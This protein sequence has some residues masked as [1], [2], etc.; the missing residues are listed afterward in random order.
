MNPIVS[1]I[2]PVYNAEKELPHAL[3]S[4]NE[5]TYRPIEVCAINDCSTD[6]SARILADFAQKS[7]DICVKISTHTTNR[8][9]AA[10]RNTGLSLA[11]GKYIYYVDADDALEPNALERLVEKAEDN[12]LDIIGHDW[13]LEFEKNGRYM[14]QRDFSTPHEAVENLMY[15]VM[16]W[17]LWLFMTKRSLYTENNILF[18]EGMN[19]GEDMMVTIKLFLSADKVGLLHQGLYHYRQCNEQSLTKVYSKKHIEQVTANVNEVEH[20]IKVHE[21]SHSPLINHLKLNIKLPLLISDDKEKYQQWRSWFPEAND[22]I[23]DNKHQ[24]FRTRLVQWLA[25]QN[26]YWAVWLYYK[27]VYKFVYGIL[28]K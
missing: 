28:Y 21:P 3:K 26:L 5:Q 13:I 14:R 23:L 18:S 11:T 12:N 19:M 1:I 24:P 6:Q 22:V 17:N 15:G 7:S 16:R 9:V 4:V 25:A 20:Y 2:I 8:G 10:A 27:V